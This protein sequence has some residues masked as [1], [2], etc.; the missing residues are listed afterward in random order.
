MTLNVV[1]NNQYVRP[2]N[3][4][5]DDNTTANYDFGWEARLNGR[6][7]DDAYI[8]IEQSEYGLSSQPYTLGTRIPLGIAVDP[9]RTTPISIEFEIAKMENFNPPN[10]FIYDAQTDIYHNVSNGNQSILL[11]AGHHVNRFFVTFIDRTLSTIDVQ[12]FADITAYQ[13]NAL[14]QLN[15]F[16]P[17]AIELKSIDIYDLAGRLVASKSPKVVQ[18]NYSFDTANYAQGIYIVKMTNADDEQKS[19]K[20]S[21]SNQ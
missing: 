13:N 1:T 18:A 4:V 3:F 10:V 15:I 8:R 2:L 16:N 20:V 12:A 11:P 14:M 7:D 6:N 5:F 9:Q 19:V 17:Q 21:V